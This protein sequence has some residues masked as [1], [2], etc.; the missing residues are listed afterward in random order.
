MRFLD[1]MSDS[2]GLLFSHPKLFLPKLAVAGLY[3]VSIAGT[4]FSTQRLL[5]VAAGEL[6]A[7]EINGIF[8]LLLGLLAF[9]LFVLLAD[10][11]VGAMYSELARMFFSGKAISFVFALKAVRKR[12]FPIVGANLFA[13]VVSALLTVPFSLGISFALASGNAPLAWVFA[14]LSV[15]VIFA[16]IVA[17]YLVGPVSVFEERG[18][19]GIF[20]RGLEMSRKNLANVSKAAVL[21]MSLSLLSYGFAWFLGDPAALA[22]F[23]LS[24]I[25]TGVIATYIIVLNPVFYLE[26]GLGKG[27]F[28]PGGRTSRR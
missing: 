18:V 19:F 26:F 4:V 7:A 21:Q 12:I 6:P 9:S 10:V 20:S 14:G 15:A 1:V 16:L 8:S 13:V 5:A 27:G 25:L 24:R 11:V 23:V 22:L 17:F 2:L 3:G 28:A